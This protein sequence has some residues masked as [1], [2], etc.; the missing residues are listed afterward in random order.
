MKYLDVENWKRKPH[1][2]LFRNMDIPYF[3]ITANVDITNTYKFVK[4][5]KYSLFK[6]FVYMT[7]FVSNSIE[8]FKYRLRGDKVLIHEIVSPSFTYLVE[9]DV[10][11]FC[12]VEYS[13]NVFEFLKRTD[14]VIEGMKGKSGLSEP[15]DRD[16][17]IFISY[18]P[19]ISFTSISHTMKIGSG[20]S[21]PRISWGKF[22]EENG[23]LKMPY[24]VQ[25]HHAMMDGLH[26]GKYYEKI[27]KLLENPEIIFK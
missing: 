26:V 3:N 21:I 27:Q 5:N 13:E 4:A 10:F 8:E 22:F 19:W 16:D 15:P 24:S 2:D 7:S 6:T 23:K 9:E 17:F 18:I 12:T 14:S 25:V 11:S 20:D 1:F